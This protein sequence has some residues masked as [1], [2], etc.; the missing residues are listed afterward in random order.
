MAAQFGDILFYNGEELRMAT[1]PLDQYLSQK[2]DIQ[3]VSRFM[4][5]RELYNCTW[6]IIDNKLYFIKLS[7]YIEGYVEVDINYL[8]PGQNKVFANWFSGEIR[9]PQGERLDNVNMGFSTLYE[10][11]LFLVI[12][13]GKLVNQYLVD[14]H[15]KY[16]QIKDRHKQ[17]K[18]FKV[19]PIVVFVFVFV[20]ICFGI[21]NF[22]KFDTPT[23]NLIS[24][25]IVSEAVLL[26]GGLIP[27][28]FIFK[29]DEKKQDIIGRFI[30]IDLILLVLTGISTSVYYLINLGT[31]LGYMITA[32]I[33]CG[34][35]YLIYLAI[36][37]LIK[38]KRSKI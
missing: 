2:P 30:F 12:E 9:V 35:G 37:N 26:I 4:P 11:D 29:E 7:A 13:N 14:N 16:Q 32:V 1:K 10:K 38:N 6:E 8:F 36:Y 28:I 5:Y 24:I 25:I 34:I 23:A 17:E 15:P 31:I 19:L 21:Y 22:I 27:F 18:F 3:F 20:V 33:F